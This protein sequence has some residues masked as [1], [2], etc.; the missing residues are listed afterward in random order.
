MTAEPHSATRNAERATRDADRVGFA[1]GY[2]KFANAREIGKLMR[3]AEE[4]GF[5]MG[6]FSETIEL[7]RDSVT[8]LAAIGLATSRLVLGATQIVRLRSPV[9]M[10]Q[11]LA[12]LDELTRGR[13][14][15]APGACTKSHARVHALEPADPAQSLREYVEAMRLLLTGEKVSYHGTYVNFDDVGL[16]WQPFRTRIPLYFP[17]TS[18]TGLKLAGEL[19]EGVVLNAVCS[20]EYT[21]NAIA[22]MRQAAQAAGRDFSTFLIAQ[23]VNCSIEDT[24]AAALDAIRWEVATKMDPVQRPFIARP[25]M[26][27]GEPYIRAEHL[28]R[29]D[30]AYAEGGL[31]ALVAAVP[32]SYVEGM[33]ASGTPDEVRA[34][35]EAYRRAG[36]QLPLL[37]PAALHQT[38]RL[39][40]LFAS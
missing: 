39:L 37:R 10:A 23:I 28:P 19:G 3:Q 2:G 35:V 29:F 20:P 6:F 7:M 21:A 5:E 34:R 17:A 26:L 11:T 8:A 9:L 27:V 24:H 22:I 25:K 4:R 40:D 16:A 30:A 38:Q 15:L 12:T 36:V 1:L 31:P 33:T 14:T 18:R 32:D 13:M